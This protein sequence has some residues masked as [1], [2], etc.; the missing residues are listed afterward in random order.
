MAMFSL[1]DSAQCLQ[2]FFVSLITN[3]F[4][5]LHGMCLVVAVVWYLCRR[6]QDS[7]F[8][9]LVLRSAEEFRIFFKQVTFR[10]IHLIN[11]IFWI[12][13]LVLKLVL[14][15]LRILLIESMQSFKWL[16]DLLYRAEAG[17]MKE[18]HFHRNIY[19]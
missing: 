12:P 3:I 6:K 14:I 5:G 19:W 9:G 18:L 8:P 11:S 2:P 16:N 4:T 15:R 7:H 1:S 17:Y 13:Y 10:L